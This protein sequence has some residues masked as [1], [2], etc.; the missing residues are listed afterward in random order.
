MEKITIPESLRSLVC[1]E[2]RGLSNDSEYVLQ[3][4]A[5][6][7]DGVGIGSMEKGWLAIVPIQESYGIKVLSHKSFLRTSPV[8]KVLDF[9]N[10]VITFKTEG[11]IYTLQELK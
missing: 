7:R 9:T 2:F 10:G 3:K 1:E 11:G 4:V 5:S 8:V 6:F